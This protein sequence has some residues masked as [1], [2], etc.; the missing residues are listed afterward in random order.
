MY[1]D[2]EEHKCIAIL[3]REN[4]LEHVHFKHRKENTLRGLGE[5]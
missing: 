1:S 5:M 4:F 2:S 3:F